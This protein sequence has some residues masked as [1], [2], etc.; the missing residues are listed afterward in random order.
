MDSINDLIALNK[1]REGK[2][3]DVGR[4]VRLETVVLSC[5]DVHIQWAIIIKNCVHI[6]TNCLLE[7]RSV[8]IMPKEF[9][10]ESKINT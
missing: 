9:F 5:S 2:P 1:L 10:N 6:T 8:F 7:G 4:E 3:M